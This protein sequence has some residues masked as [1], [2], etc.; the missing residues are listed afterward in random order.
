MESAEK[1]MLKKYGIHFLRTILM[2]GAVFAL[3]LLFKPEPKGPVWKAIVL[4]AIAAICIHFLWGSW[5]IIRAGI[6][7]DEMGQAIWM[8]AGSYA[9]MASILLA[10]LYGVLEG[11]TGMPRVSMTVVSVGMI[12]IGYVSVVVVQRRYA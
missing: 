1:L 12:V 10:S 11:I 2:L 6:K 4:G 7:T 3:G 8:R 9:H 5:R